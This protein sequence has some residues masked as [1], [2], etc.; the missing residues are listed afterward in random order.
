MNNKWWLRFFS[1]LVLMLFSQ[2]I[3][4]MEQ[5]DP[6]EFEEKNVPELPAE[7][8]VSI[9]SHSIAN[10]I[11]QNLNLNDLNNLEKNLCNLVKNFPQY[12]ANNLPWRLICR[13][14]SLLGSNS[15][16]DFYFKYFLTVKLKDIDIEIRKKLLKTLKLDKQCSNLIIVLLFLSTFDDSTNSFGEFKRLYNLIKDAIKRRAIYLCR[17]LVTNNKNFLADFHGLGILNFD[18]AKF[19]DKELLE[20]LITNQLLQSSETSHLIEQK[21]ETSFDIHELIFCLQ[22]DLKNQLLKDTIEDANFQT[23]YLNSEIARAIYNKDIEAIKDLLSTT[24]INKECSQNGFTPLMLAVIFEAEEIITY[25]LDNKPNPIAKNNFKRNA[26]YYATACKKPKILDLFLDRTLLNISS[27]ELF[28][29][30]ILTENFELSDVMF[31]IASNR[32]SP[33]LLSIAAK[34]N[35]VKMLKELLRFFCRSYYDTAFLE[36][37][38]NNS[39]D[40]VEFLRNKISDDLAYTVTLPY[41][42][43]RSGDLF[44]MKLLI[45]SGFNVNLKSPLDRSPLDI[46]KENGYQEIIALLE[47]W[48]LEHPSIES[49]PDQA[50]VLEQKTKKNLCLIS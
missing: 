50:E 48:Q 45:E 15:E 29:T 26:L 33:N 36:A 18:P 35:R 6:S 19:Q 7:L 14:F 31:E 27:K 11:N 13:E 21:D 20:I 23:K 10:Y 49:E 4:S 40:I 5:T 9:I 1:F 2:Y 42:I 24:D 44:K 30:A 38:Q 3:F 25:L 28:K 16:L 32:L 17:P 47:K 46:A 39:S 12:I 22:S 41:D 8:K 37:I 43:A 34:K